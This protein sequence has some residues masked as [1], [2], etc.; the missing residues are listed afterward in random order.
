MTHPA[1][2][3]LSASRNAEAFGP[4]REA[5][6]RPRLDD[7]RAGGLCVPAGPIVACDDPELL[8]RC[9]RIDELCGTVKR[10][11]AVLSRTE[12]TAYRLRR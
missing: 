6:S 12:T 2:K 3:L 5:H 8:L 10:S 1:R 9:T 11:L 4:Q 7:R